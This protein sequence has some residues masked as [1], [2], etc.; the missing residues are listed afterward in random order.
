VNAET[1][2]L[3]RIVRQI[4]DVILSFED[5]GRHVS[6]QAVLSYIRD[7][8]TAEIRRRRRTHELHR[9]LAVIERA[10]DG[11][12]TETRAV[13]GLQRGR[14]SGTPP[15][16]SRCAASLEKAFYRSLL[17]ERAPVH[18]RCRDGYEVPCAVVR[19]AGTSA[20]L[21][22]TADGLELFLTRNIVS[23]TTARTRTREGRERDSRT[24][25]TDK[26]VRS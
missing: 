4:A 23:I 13:A 2:N 10:M 19:D 24:V 7:A 12:T 14:P 8:V 11:P 20:L 6:D 25:L 5:S 3:N 21:I 17:E 1:L 26:G 9:T 22:E 18:L 16:P 15:A